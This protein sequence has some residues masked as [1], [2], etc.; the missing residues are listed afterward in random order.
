MSTNVYNVAE[1]N[2]YRN[3][4]DNPIATITCLNGINNM[5]KGNI[6]AF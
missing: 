3:G 2:D 1:K 4:Y 5:E 6:M